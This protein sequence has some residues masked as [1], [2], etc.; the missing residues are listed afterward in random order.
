MEDKIYEAHHP[1]GT[2]LSGCTR[3]P[4]PPSLR[5]GQGS[6][7]LSIHLL[8]PLPSLGVPQLRVLAIQGLEAPRYL[9]LPPTFPDDNRSSTG[10]F[11]GGFG[12]HAPLF[13]QLGPRGAAGA[14]PAYDG[15]NLVEASLAGEGGGWR[16]D[17]GRAGVP[18]LDCVAR[19]C[20]L[21]GRLGCKG[22]PHHT[23]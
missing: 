9:P 23:I 7:V 2:Q 20:G 3:L 12:R 4:S 14:F 1:S 21:L 22:K 10:I 8:L 5:P 18:Q 16:R 13:Q 6:A 19:L 17:R 15:V 11:R